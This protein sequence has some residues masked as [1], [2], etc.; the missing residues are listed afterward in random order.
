MHHQVGVGQTAV[1]FFNAADRED[2]ARGFAGELVGTVAS[3]D[4]D[5]EGIHLGGFNKVNG[6]IRVGQQLIMAEG[7]FKTVAVFG[8]TLA[9]FQRAEAT[10]FAFNTDA[11]RVG[12]IHHLGGD[13]HVVLEA[14]R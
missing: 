14:S 13:T 7:T 11:N 12:N 8:F 4:R 6:F 5:R 3:T 2:F 1:N 10:Q 9:C